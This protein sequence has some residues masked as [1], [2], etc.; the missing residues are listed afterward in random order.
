M[1]YLSIK[2]SYLPPKLP[3]PFALY[4]NPY[5]QIFYDS[6]YVCKKQQWHFNL[7]YFLT[8]PSVFLAGDGLT[9][10]WQRPCSSPDCASQP[11]SPPLQ[12]NCSYQH[13]Y[14]GGLNFFFTSILTFEILN[15][16]LTVSFSIFYPN[17]GKNATEKVFLI[18]SHLHCELSLFSFQVDT[19]G[20][21]NELSNSMAKR[22]DDNDWILAF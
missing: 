22:K 10:H 2:V 21:C 5:T 19:L 3:A 1:F 14:S 12:R 17:W 18:L 13:S 8:F 11:H 16:S 9:E 7:D 20:K 6:A 4:P 15:V